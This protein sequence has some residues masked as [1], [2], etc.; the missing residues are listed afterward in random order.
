MRITQMGA[1]VLHRL[2]RMFVYYDAVVVDTPILDDT[3]RPLISDVHSIQDRLDR[4]EAFVRYLRGQFSQLRGLDTG[5]DLD[6]M[7]NDVRRDISEVRARLDRAAS[8]RA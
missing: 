4:A 2:G 1:Y 3:A 7:A 6:A 8:R 5:L